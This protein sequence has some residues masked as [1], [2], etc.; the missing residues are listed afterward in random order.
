MLSHV[1]TVPIEKCWCPMSPGAYLTLPETKRQIP[2]SANARRRAAVNRLSH[3]GVKPG[4]EAWLYFTS[5]PS[6]GGRADSKA[7]TKVSCLHWMI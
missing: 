5:P 3:E 7:L 6:V 1:H 2:D 4:H